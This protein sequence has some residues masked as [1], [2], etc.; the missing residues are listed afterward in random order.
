MCG[1][2]HPSWES[3]ILLDPDSQT[4]RH[5]LEISQAVEGNGV[6]RFVVVVGQDEPD[7]DAEYE[8]DLT[9]HYNQN[10]RLRLGK[11][12]VKFDYL[13]TSFGCPAGLHPLGELRR[14]PGT[15]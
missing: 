9:L 6:D 11:V 2:T 15:R 3:N 13:H 5:R 12:R 7:T 8:L 4:Q 1:V 14:I 10:E